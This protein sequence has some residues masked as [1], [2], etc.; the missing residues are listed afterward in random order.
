VGD[1][2]G[3]Q[4]FDSLLPADRVEVMRGA[5]EGRVSME[6]FYAAVLAGLTL[7]DS[8]FVVVQAD[9]LQTFADGVD[10][11]LQ[12]ARGTGVASSYVAVATSGGTTFT[13]PAFH[14]EIRSDEGFFHITF[15]GATDVSIAN[16]SSESTYV[17]IDKTGA[18]QQQITAPTMQDWA[19]KIFV[20][21]VAVNTATNVVIG[22]EYLNNPLGGYGITIRALYKYLVAQGV[23]FKIGQTI[24]GRSDGLGFDVSAG[25]LLEL[26]GTGNIHEAHELAYD[27][28]ATNNFVLLDKTSI[29][30]TTNTQL[31]KFWDNNDTIT[32]LG[33][34]TLVAHRLYRF[35]N[36]N[37]ALQY[38]QGNYANM[39]LAKAG[40][41]L[42]DFVI[43]PRLLNASFFGWWFIESVATTT[44][45]TVTTDF[46][47][48]TIG[49]QGGSS[50]GLSGALLKGNAL[51]DVDAAAAKTNL[52]LGTMAEE[53]SGDYALR[54][55][56]WAMVNHGA[57]ASTA[58]P[59]GWAGVIWYGSVQPDNITGQDIVIRTDEAT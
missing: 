53:A 34:T 20:M 55:D 47:E 33:S 1:F 52:G 12:K 41:L 37:F 54:S 46:R 51:S 56:S 48:Y 27:A 29:V 6:V 59:T 42:E 5:T 35:S 30:S 26:G 36:G 25:T 32:A 57:T 24:T 49:V 8:G 14:G 2:S 39:S 40:S 16:L 44:D 22:F 50:G 43:N 7:D 9:N 58:R 28:V 18:L 19:R 10:H 4:I 31:P 13:V 3:A 23:P 15:A 21:R 38:G 11:A 17:Y 45:G